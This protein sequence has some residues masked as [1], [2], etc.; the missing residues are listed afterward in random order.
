MCNQFN[1]LVMFGMELINTPHKKALKFT[2][3]LNP[4]FKDLTF[5][6]I[7]TDVTFEG[8]MEMVLLNAVFKKKVKNEPKKTGG[9]APSTTSARV[10]QHLMERIRSKSCSGRSAVG[11]GI[12]HWTSFLA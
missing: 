1:E 8:P 5:S 7:F 9:K 10:E 12:L 2:K 4:P 3:G 6:H 11:R